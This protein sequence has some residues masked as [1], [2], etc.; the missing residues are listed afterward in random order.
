MLELERDVGLVIK[1]KILR[2]WVMFGS[3][4]HLAS[5]LQHSFLSYTIVS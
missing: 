3:F 2:P 4:A 1:S 5:N